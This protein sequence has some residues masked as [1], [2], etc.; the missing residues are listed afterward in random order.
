LRGSEWGQFRIRWQGRKRFKDLTKHNK[1]IRGEKKKEGRI[2][3]LTGWMSAGQEN[4]G[5][6]VGKGYS[7]TVLEQKGGGEKKN[8]D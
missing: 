7:S 4:K 2:S 6:M 3:P 5:R 1:R 8:R